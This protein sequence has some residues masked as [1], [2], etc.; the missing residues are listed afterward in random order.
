[1]LVQSAPRWLGLIKGVDGWTKSFKLGL[2]FYLICVLESWRIWRNTHGDNL[3]WIRLTEHMCWCLDK[4]FKLG[5][6]LYLIYVLESCRSWRNTHG[7]T[8]RGQG[9]WI[10]DGS[11]SLEIREGWLGHSR[12]HKISTS[13]YSCA[14]EAN[15]I[16]RVWKMT[17]G[18][19]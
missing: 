17:H 15:Y 4:E 13:E 9:R 8:L 14:W 6:S 1:M 3:V 18:V 19:S 2:S 11:R 5:L 10:L 7:E 16:D 12:N